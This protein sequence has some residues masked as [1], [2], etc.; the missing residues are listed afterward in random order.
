[1]VNSIT[2]N[3]AL[4][5]RKKFVSYISSTVSSLYYKT[6]KT[7]DNVTGRIPIE[8]LGLS[9]GDITIPAH[10][11]NYM[12]DAV[13]G[14]Y[15]KDVNDIG[16]VVTGFAVEDCILD[17]CILDLNALCA[18]SRQFENKFNDMK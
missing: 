12:D 14:I 8:N 1:M 7:T 4:D 11:P 17:I 16:F 3:I 9:L 18:I 2:E 6:N 5:A 10:D 13:H 15:V